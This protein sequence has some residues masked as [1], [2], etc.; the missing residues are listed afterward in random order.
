M[1]KNRLL[2]ALTFALLVVPASMVP[3]AEARSETKCSLLNTVC[4]TAIA[5]V[6]VSC[7]SNAGLRHCTPVGTPG[8]H[9]F[10]PTKLAGT[11]SWSGYVCG[12]E[13]NNACYSGTS[14]SGWCSWTSSA[15]N[16]CGTT[17]SVTVDTYTCFL[18][19]A[20][21]FVYADSSASADSR[22]PLNLVVE[23]ASQYTSDRAYAS[24][25]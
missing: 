1:N 21:G 7:G 16:G 8:G 13:Y 6:I 19:R 14:R 9:G 15:T 2:I 10:S 5:E 3:M 11:M 17:R 18:C 23:R 4:V 20:S 22:T 12:S 25:G 24:Y